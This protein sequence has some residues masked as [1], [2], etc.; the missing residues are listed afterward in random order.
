MAVALVVFHFALPFVILLS[1][2]VKRRPGVLAAVATA[3][4]VARFVD[5]T[6]LVAPAF[7]EGGVVPHWLDLTTLAALGGIT[8]GLV[9]RRVAAH[10]LLPLRD[11]SLAV[12][13]V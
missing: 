12:E 4:L 5:L 9:I 1:R 3:M 8:V 11:P 7:H 13:T 2:D 10:A 6:W